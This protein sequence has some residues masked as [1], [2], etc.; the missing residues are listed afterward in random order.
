MGKVE[1]KAGGWRLCSWRV[2]GVRWCTKEG[3]V[4]KVGEKRVWMAQGVLF[5]LCKER[6]VE[7]MVFVQIGVM[8]TLSP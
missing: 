6:M 2:K 7:Y 8:K 4:D 3:K 5:K 1:C